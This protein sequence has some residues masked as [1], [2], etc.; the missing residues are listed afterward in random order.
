MKLCMFNL[1]RATLATVVSVMLA[2]NVAHCQSLWPQRS[3]QRI[4]LF[5]DTQ[6]RHPGDLLTVLIREVT[7]VENR[8]RRA[9]DRNV[10]SRGGFSFAGALTGKL[11]NKSDTANFEASGNGSGKFN[12]SS[13]FDVQRGFV[14]RITAVVVHRYANGNLLVE[15][16]RSRV[17]SGERR[18]LCVSGI[19]RPIDIQ[20]DNTVESQFVGNFHVCYRGDGVESRFN[21]QG[22]MTRTWNRFRPL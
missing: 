2:T 18:S 9:L 5:S 6:A 17:V 13:Q 22:W 15:G 8:D 3:P 21:T 12:G 4:S 11:G 19:V 16:R 14:D 20:A 7:D 1:K 10:E